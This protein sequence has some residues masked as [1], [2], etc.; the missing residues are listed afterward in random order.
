MKGALT[1]IPTILIIQSGQIARA[2]YGISEDLC[3]PA[4]SSNVCSGQGD[5][6]FGKCHC[7][8][9]WTGQ[10]CEECQGCRSPKPQKPTE[11]CSVYR[12]CIEG[13]MFGQYWHDYNS[14]Y[15]CK[16][17]CSKFSFVNPTP[18]LEGDIVCTM[19]FDPVCGLDGQT[20]GNRC[21][22]EAA[23]VAVHCEGQCPCPV[24][25]CT[26]HKNLDGDDLCP[27]YKFVVNDNTISVWRPPCLADDLEVNVG[28]WK[29]GNAIKDGDRYP[30]GWGTL[31]YKKED[32]L[33]RDKY[34]GNM[35][36]GE[37]EGHGSLYWTDGSYY[38]GTWSD[39]VKNGEGTLFYANGDIYTGIWGN[40]KK[41]GEGKYVYSSGEKSKGRDESTLTSKYVIRPDDQ[42]EYFTGQY[43]EGTRTT[44]AY[45]TSSGSIYNG[46]FSKSGKYDGEGV[47]I[48]AC[49][50][51]YVGN[52]IDG[53]MSGK[54]TLTYAQG[55]TYTGQFSDGKFNGFGKFSWSENHYFEGEFRDGKMTG[56]GVYAFED[57]GFYDNSAGLYYPNRDDKSSYL[58]AHFD[59]TKLRVNR[60]VVENTPRPGYG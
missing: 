42:W 54:G 51:K 31:K 14:A 25:A 28:L 8:V 24:E 5:C 48:W 12:S 60:K 47:Y 15:E 22:S 50:K 55:W 36:Y 20:Y 26:F 38:S 41:S 34:T 33:N 17:K 58:T 57:G 39:N 19:E 45:N 4:D 59:G 9:G 44:G 3:V 40:E 49:G 32:H 11:D 6:V 43:T 29:G 10:F 52:F 23:G 2:G 1:L 27:A 35:A 46:A 7:N 37:R 13:A 56:D 16:T 21:G 53:E 18:D 30:H